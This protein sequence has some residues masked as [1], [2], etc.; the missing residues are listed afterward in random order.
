MSIEEIQWRWLVL[1]RRIAGVCGR[2]MAVGQVAGDCCVGGGL[3]RW[4]ICCSQREIAAYLVMAGSLIPGVRRHRRELHLL[5]ISQTDRARRRSPE[6]CVIADRSNAGARREMS[7]RRS[8]ERRSAGQAE[9]IA[10]P[11]T[12]GGDH[13]SRRRWSPERRSAPRDRFGDARRN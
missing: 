5:D 4:W 11:L 13:S 10:T 12:A 3:H 7:R 9:M 2:V 1:G 8:P 6:L